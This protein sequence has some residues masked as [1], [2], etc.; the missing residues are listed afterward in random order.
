MSLPTG[1]VDV[2]DNQRFDE[3]ALDAYL[4]AHLGNYRG[5][6]R[7]AQFAGGQSNPT[8]LLSTPEQSWVLRKKPPGK[9]LPSAHAVEREFR[10]CNALAATDVP[11]PRMDLLCEDDAVIGTPFYVMEYLDGRVLVDAALPGV[12]PTDRAAISAEQIRVLASLHNVD[13]AALGLS[14][15]GKPGNYFARQIGRWTKQYIAAKTDEI[16]PMDR[17]MEWLPAHAPSDDA[18]TLVHGDY[19]IDNMIFAHDGARVLGVLDWEL[20]TL[21]HP[22]ADL[23]YYCMKY[24]MRAPRFGACGAVGVPTEEQTIAEYCRFVGRPGIAGWNFYLAFS[25]FRLA[26]IVQGVYQRGLQGNASS[27]RAL[28]MKDFAISS[29]TSGWKL[30]QRTGR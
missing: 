9:L 21:G 24:H 1:V 28:Q 16:E 18:T 4:Q 30:A 11:V 27:D 5:P 23:A 19:R 15:Y 26:S 2:R 13:Y 14:D 6:L 12:T 29:A 3:V 8:F 25:F 10:I 7:V 22:L 17:L 20:S